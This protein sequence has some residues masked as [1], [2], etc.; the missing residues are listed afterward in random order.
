MTT[1][2]AETAVEVD[3][4]ANEVA[5]LLQAQLKR[6]NQE[7]EG[8]LT[9]TILAQTAV[10]LRLTQYSFANLVA[11]ERVAVLEIKAELELEARENE[12]LADD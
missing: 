7:D 1:P 2:N 3:Q 6:V 9:A 4:I 12:D 11:E 5:D 10:L 8:A